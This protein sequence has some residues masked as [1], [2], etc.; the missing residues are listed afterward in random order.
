MKK[1][2]SILLLTLVSITSHSQEK[3]EVIKVKSSHRTIYT[4]IIIDAPPAKVWEV[5]MDFDSY[6]N[7]AVFFKGMKGEI[8]DQG[9]I[10]AYIEMKPKKD[11]VKEVE[12][13]IF[14]EEGKM[15]GWS[16][17]VT[18]GIRDNHRFIV[19]AATEGKTRFI[20]SDEFKKGATCLLG[21]YVT[22]LLSEKYPE[23]NRSL[24]AEV[25]RRF[26]N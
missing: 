20:Q 5:L 3:I 24:K 15:F 25:E 23:F 14:Y 13:V 21:G 18:L 16:D 2:I 22:K 8:K 26:K 6:S 4:D 19:E 12:H 17:K 1:Y 9:N 10:L 7:W 11:K